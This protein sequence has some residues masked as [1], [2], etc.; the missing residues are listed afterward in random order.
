MNNYEIARN[1]T[2]YGLADEIDEAKLNAFIET[3]IKQA[4]VNIDYI[5]LVS[6]NTNQLMNEVKQIVKD[7]CKFGTIETL[8]QPKNIAMASVGAGALFGGGFLAG[9]KLKIKKKK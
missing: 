6:G 5:K 3:R 7:T 1:M 2:N 8:K 9:K 4:L